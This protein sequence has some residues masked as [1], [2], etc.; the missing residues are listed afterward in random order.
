MFALVDL[1]VVRECTR[2]RCRS[3]FK[4]SIFV[5]I[6]RLKLITGVPCA[7]KF[8]G[9]SRKVCQHFRKIARIVFF[10]F[11]F[12]NGYQVQRIQMF[13][14]HPNKRSEGQMQYGCFMQWF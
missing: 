1:H 4:C 2:A 11:L 3:V 10:V 13:L 12:E 7:L 6:V 14:K 8:S 9:K 5:L